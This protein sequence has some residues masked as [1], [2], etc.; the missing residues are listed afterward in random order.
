MIGQ[1][2]WTFAATP[3]RAYSG[4][5]NYIRN[6]DTPGCPGGNSEL[7]AVSQVIQGSTPY[8][9]VL[10]I[11]HADPDG[12]R[13]A[14][15]RSD[16]RRQLRERGP[17]RPARRGDG[18]T[19]AVGLSAA[20]HRWRL[21]QPGPASAHIKFRDDYTVPGAPGDRD[22]IVKLRFYDRTK[23]DKGYDIDNPV[24]VPG[25]STSGQLQ[26]RD[27]HPQ[28]PL[29]QDRDD[30]RLRQGLHGGHAALS[31]AMLPKPLPQDCKKTSYNS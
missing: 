23:H 9:D 5:F 6:G 15:V 11:C 20:H 24:D 22:P 27:Q 18:Q 13:G 19:L 25:A 17:A 26:L 1:Q 28:A 2:V 16:R 21:R 30:D 12:T 8:K 31:H 29:H 14:G 7:D 4:T 3:P 10:R